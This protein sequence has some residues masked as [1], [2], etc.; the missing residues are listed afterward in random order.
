MNGAPFDAV[1][2]ITRLARFSELMF[3][4]VPAIVTGLDMPDSDI[5]ID[6]MGMPAFA[7]ST[8]A[9][10]ECGSKASGAMEQH[11]TEKMGLFFRASG[12][13][14]TSDASS[15]CFFAS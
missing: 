9:S 15:T 2:E 5:D 14:T 1:C 11:I 13:P 8:C 3:T 10:A 7:N 4:T 6:T 12:P